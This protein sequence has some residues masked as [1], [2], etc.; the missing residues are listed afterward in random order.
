MRR[1]LRCL[2]ERGN[3]L[4]CKIHQHFHFQ[5]TS[6]EVNLPIVPARSEPRANCY[7]AEHI[8][9]PHRS[10]ALAQL[11]ICES[12][13][14]S[15]FPGSCRAN[16]WVFSLSQVSSTDLTLRNAGHQHEKCTKIRVRFRL[17]SGLHASCGRPR[18]RGYDIHTSRHQGASQLG[19]KATF[20]V[21]LRSLNWRAQYP[22]NIIP[23]RK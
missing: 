23:Y 19:A 6:E 13:R 20:E 17:R 5:N 15:G 14:R 22:K 9:S 4:R 11:Q 2:I 1:T 18:P 21:R 7:S 16:L 3:S 12:R 8:I 10:Y